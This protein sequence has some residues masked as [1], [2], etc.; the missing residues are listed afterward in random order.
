MAVKLGSMEIV[1]GLN[2]KAFDKALKGVGRKFGR[3]GREL[4]SAGST[5]TRGITLPLAGIG[6]AAA[7]VAIDW[8][9]AFAN[10]RKTVKGSETQL[11]ELSRGI[12]DLSL[13]LP[14]AAGELASIAEEAGRLGIARTDILKF[15]ETVV[16]LAETSTLSSE[17]AAISL[18]RLTKQTSASADDVKRL[19]SSLT[20]LGSEF[21]T[22]ESSIAEMAQ[23]LSV[24]GDV[25]GLSAHEILGFSA[26]MSAA[27]IQAESGGTAM[28]DVFI[29]IA[30]AVDEGGAELDK[31][32]KIAGTTS[33][34]FKKQFKTDASGALVDFVKGLKNV[35]DSGGSVFEALEN[36]GLSGKRQRLVLLALQKDTDGLTKALDRSKTA[37]IEELAV[38]ALANERFKTTGAQIQKLINQVVD[39]ARELGD[40]LFPAIKSIVNIFQSSFLPS[41]KG[42]IDAF[43]A[44]EPSTKAM[45][46]VITGL[47]AGIGPLL[48]MLGQLAF[49]IQA[50]AGAMTLL[51]A[52]PF[53]AVLI[54]L[55]A[56]VGGMALYNS[57]AEKMKGVSD[58]VG[59][60]LDTQEQRIHDLS[61]ALKKFGKIRALEASIAAREKQGADLEAGIEEGKKAGKPRIPFQG[62]IEFF[63]MLDEAGDRMSTV[64]EYG[65]EIRRLQKDTE[66][67]TEAE[68]RGALAMAQSDKVMAEYKAQREEA[69][70][71]YSKESQAISLKNRQI[72][73]E[74]QLIGR[75]LK[76][77]GDHSSELQASKLRLEDYREELAE[78]RQEELKGI[79]SKLD[80]S[81]AT[82][83][84][85][86]NLTKALADQKPAIEE[87][88]SLWEEW[89][90]RMTEI[91]KGTSDAFKE[92][93]FDVMQQFSDGFG[94]AVAATLVAGKSF[95]DAM[96]DLWKSIASTV[97]SRLISMGVQLLLF[98]F[99]E[100]AV[101]KSS[102]MGTVGAKATETFVSAYASV[103]KAVPFPANVLMA[104]L[105]AGAQAAY[106][107]GAGTKG[108][109]ALAEGGIL[110]SPQVVL[111]GEAGPEAVI[112]LD[113][114]GEFTGGRQ[115]VNLYI[116]GELVTEAVIEGMPSVLEARLGGI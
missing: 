46:I 58:D 116:D 59:V 44:L 56:L 76:I 97:I 103:I 84:A 55:T 78:L 10:V 92:F 4:S 112:P 42:W 24:T 98:S 91:I 52:H 37:W 53:A 11:K 108:I 87:N 30:A 96:K 8:E 79:K 114:L 15:T 23:R 95:G 70:Q 3:M 77:S 13:E 61:E 85:S 45:I 48:F 82:K 73:L 57:I 75:L 31:F 27:G 20:V 110:T 12:R 83:E 94:A 68:V 18:A 90:K 69:N 6:I 22:N 81:D 99:I 16:Q 105:V 38:E 101:M 25:I 80:L 7:K 107:M 1:L 89:G 14:V 93:G 40:A 34:K 5:L 111:A 26:A 67:L 54:G 64:Q 113:R 106:V 71:L 17:E 2:V 74:E 62:V 33:A 21:E 41:L 19:A 86:E 100:K 72:A 9:T 50:V 60:S 88:L 109:A 32:S 51:A 36:I 29:K 49:L 115:T 66:G 28:G 47:V 102:L 43:K 65:E 39:I 35:K 63:F 104:P